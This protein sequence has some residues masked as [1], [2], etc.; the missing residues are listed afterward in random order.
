MRWIPGVVAVALVAAGRSNAVEAVS[1][2]D[3][4]AQLAHW[5]QLGPDVYFIVYEGD[6]DGIEVSEEAFV[7]RGLPAVGESDRFSVENLFAE[8]E[9]R[10][11]RGEVVRASF[12]GDFGYP[13]RVQADGVDVSV[14]SFRGATRALGCEGVVAGGAADLRWEATE[15]VLNAGLYQRWT[16]ESG[17]PIRTDVMSTFSG[18]DHCGWEALEFLL[19]GE[20]DGGPVDP[21]RMRHYVRDELDVLGDYDSIDRSRVL[22]AADARSSAV[23][24]GYRRDG[25]SIWLDGE[26][27]YWITGTVAEEFVLDAQREIL[28]G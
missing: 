9:A 7:D 6:V 23:D 13:T 14:K 4:D 27:A 5:T 20:P 15:R 11:S 24:T 1:S 10:V 21:S 12:D 22:L 28:C 19:V 16:D 25:S 26:S 18:P 3:L 17:C 8:M 2:S